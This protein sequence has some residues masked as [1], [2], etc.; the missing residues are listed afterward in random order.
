MS[1]PA[2]SS[3]LRVLVVDDQPDLLSMLDL[4]MQRRKYAVKTALSGDEALEVAPDFAPHV[5]ISDIGMPGMDGYQLMAHL[6]AAPD[7]APFKS[8]ALSGYDLHTET[9]R[10]RSAGYDAHLL[11]PIEFDQLFEMIEELVGEM[12]LDT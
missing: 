11:K 5:V 7:L 8:I 3:S 10:A 9:S 6:R 4:M 1:Y 2:V 12:E